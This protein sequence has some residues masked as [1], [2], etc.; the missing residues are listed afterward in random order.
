MSDMH[1]LVLKLVTPLVQG[2]V[3]EAQEFYP[4]GR[5]K[6]GS[7]PWSRLG[8]GLLKRSRLDDRLPT[9]NVLALT[10]S[11]VIV[12]P[13]GTR[14]GH[15]ERGERFASWPRAQVSASKT[16]VEVVMRPGYVSSGPADTVS[17]GMRTHR[18]NVVRLTLTTPDGV[19]IAD[20]PGG[21]PG[22]ERI[23]SELCVS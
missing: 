16:E 20:L 21:E 9:M 1:D 8:R 17:A 6:Q 13:T 5:W 3:L 23:A 19:L 18:K 12:F 2:E 15:F 11:D 4:G 7:L 10:P 22:T 14:T